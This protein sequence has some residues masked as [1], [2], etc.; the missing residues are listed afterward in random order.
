[1]LLDRGRVAFAGPTYEAVSRYRQVL[2]SAPGDGLPAGGTGIAVRVLG[3]DGEPHDQF[4]AGEPLVVEI[5]PGDA[6]PAATLTVELRDDAGLLVAQEALPLG[7]SGW[8]PG[9]SP[10]RLD[11]P[12]PPLHFGRFTVGVVLSDP[13]TG[14]PFDVVQA[15][16]AF[17]VY[18]DGPTR[19][20]VRLGGTWAAAPNSVSR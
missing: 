19:G 4:L 5:D 15:A 16:A 6:D 7:E 8:A 9:A 14:R 13:A 20:L 18:P 3:R 2:A 10:A 17:L 12:E 1:M 11:L